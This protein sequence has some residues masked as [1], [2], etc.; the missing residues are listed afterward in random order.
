MRTAV[1]SDYCV[2]C[3]VCRAWEYCD[4]SCEYWTQ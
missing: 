4:K 3:V 1:D 2:P